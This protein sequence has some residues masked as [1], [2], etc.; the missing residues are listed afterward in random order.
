MPVTK[1]LLLALQDLRQPHEDRIMWI[2]AICIDQDNDKERGHQ[3]L[4]MASIYKN[5]EKVVIWLGP[6]TELT[7][8]VFDYMSEVEIQAVK[9]ACRDWNVTN[10]RSLTIWKSVTSLPDDCSFHRSSVLRRESQRQGLHE[11][12]NR[13]WLNRVWI[14]Q[15]V[16]NARAAEV[17]CGT[18]SV[19]ARTFALIPILIGI[20]PSPHYQAILDVMPGPTR[21]NSW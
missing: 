12:L 3:V 1:S 16:A 15:E 8:V 6:A 4:Q 7:D 2:D 9:H 17:A 19:S 18:K 21:R 11:L 10:E 14:I 5:A 13:P 20:E